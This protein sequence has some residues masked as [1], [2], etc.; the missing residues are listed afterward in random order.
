LNHKVKHEIMQLC[1]P[2]MK[3]IVPKVD[4]IGKCC[5]HMFINWAMWWTNERKT[6]IM[7]ICL[8]MDSWNSLE[9]MIDKWKIMK[10]KMK[11]DTLQ[12][13]K[14]K[15]KCSKMLVA[16]SC[17]NLSRAR[18]ALSNGF[19]LLEWHPP[20]HHSLMYVMIWLWMNLN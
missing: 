18:W 11:R 4:V 13:K 19:S 2:L 16:L 5:N 12:C 8:P 9:E 15:Q 14:Q 20:T 7:C 6:M 17:Y 10:C 1:L 3:N